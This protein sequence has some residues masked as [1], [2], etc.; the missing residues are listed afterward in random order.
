[1]RRD[2]DG[3][4][5]FVARR[6]E[7]IRRRGEN[8]APGEIEDALIAHPSVVDAAVVG[9]PSELGEE[10]VKA[11]VVAPDVDLDALV[12]TLRDRLSKHKV[13]RYI[14]LVADLPRTATGRVAKHLLP[15]ERNERELDTDRP[16]AC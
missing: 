9:V 3:I 10:D 13:P 6:K 11:F 14:E 2:A 1:V 5:W 12:K 4:Y 15:R 16:T 8:I 7:I